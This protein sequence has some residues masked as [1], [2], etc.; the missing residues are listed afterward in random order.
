MRNAMATFLNH[1]LSFAFPRPPLSLVFPL[2]LTRAL[3]KRLS[4]HRFTFFESVPPQLEEKKNKRTS[5]CSLPLLSLFSSL[6][7]AFTYTHKSP[8]INLKHH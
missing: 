3:A 2:Y 8:L 7:F 4:E 6:P 5:P 1:F